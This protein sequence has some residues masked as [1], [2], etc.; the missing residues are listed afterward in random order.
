MI[1]HIVVAILALLL[2]STLNAQEGTSDSYMSRD[3]CK[4]LVVPYFETKYKKCL[5][6]SLEGGMEQCR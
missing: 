2:N 3:E 6:T 4:A 1:P 5:Y